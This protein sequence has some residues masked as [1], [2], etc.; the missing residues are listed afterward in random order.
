MILSACATIHIRIRDTYVVNHVN[1]YLLFRS[2]IF[3]TCEHKRG[4]MLKNIEHNV[5]SFIISILNWILSNSRWI[6]GSY[7]ANFSTRKIYN[8]LCTSF[9]L[10]GWFSNW[11]M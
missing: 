4:V 6:I 1:I 2:V 3:I 11:N 8:P 10:F 5:I 9:T 7:R